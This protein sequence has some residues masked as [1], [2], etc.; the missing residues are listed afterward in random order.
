MAYIDMGNPASIGRSIQKSVPHFSRIPLFPPSRVKFLQPIMTFWF[1]LGLPL[2]VLPRKRPPS[3]WEKILLSFLGIIMLM[4]SLKW[5]P[6]FMAGHCLSSPSLAI[7]LCYIDKHKQRYRRTEEDWKSK[8]VMWS[9]HFR[10]WIQNFKFWQSL[11]T[12]SHHNIQCFIHPVAQWRRLQISL[13][14]KARNLLLW[15]Q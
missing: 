14:R 2:G 1:L 7:L 11:S 5:L 10:C 12:W 4:R 13:S 8:E 9:Y 6:T 15:Q 3:A